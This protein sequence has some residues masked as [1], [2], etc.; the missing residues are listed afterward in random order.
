M[1]A[2]PCCRRYSGVDWDGGG[3]EGTSATGSEEVPPT[4]STVVCGGGRGVRS[5]SATYLVAFG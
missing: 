5:M 1:L 4:A 2:L 3:A